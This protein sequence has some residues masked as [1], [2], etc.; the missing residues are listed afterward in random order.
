MLQPVNRKGSRQSGVSCVVYLDVTDRYFSL[1]VFIL[2]PASAGPL[3]CPVG[4]RQDQ[5]VR[6]PFGKQVHKTLFGILP[7]GIRH[8]DLVR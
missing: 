6:N 8:N 3:Q 4:R 7:G 2:S 5:T 1:Y